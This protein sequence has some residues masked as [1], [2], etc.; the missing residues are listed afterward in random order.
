MGVQLTIVVAV[1]SVLL[2]VMGIY[3]Q[4]F[5]KYAIMDPKMHVLLMLARCPSPMLSELMMLDNP[6]PAIPSDMGLTAR[7][8]YHLFHKQ[9]FILYLQ[10]LAIRLTVNGILALQ[11]RSWSPFV[12]TSRSLDKMTR[13]QIAKAVVYDEAILWALSACRTADRAYA[14]SA[15]SAWKDRVQVHL[16][17]SMEQDNN[18]KAR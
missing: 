9:C 2:Q 6:V 1:I 10:T 5:L 18:N 4:P 12:N 17:A 7:I 13:M 15:G 14:Y 8:L 16:E 11:K 3:A